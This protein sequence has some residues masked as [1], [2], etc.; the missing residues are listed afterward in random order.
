MTLFRDCLDDCGLF[1]LG[2]SGPKYTWNNRQREE[3]HVK[4]RLDRAVANGDFTT[5][6]DEYNVENIITTAS[7]HLAILIN[8]STS[9][10]DERPPVQQGFRFE[11]AWLRA[12]DYREVLEKA[13]TDRA[14]GDLSLQSTWA[15]L[16]QVA[17]SLQS[18]S[19]ETFGAIRHKI[20]KIERKLHYLRVSASG[21]G[22]DEIRN[23]E[24][25]LCK[26]FEREE[27]MARQ[28]S[29]VEWLREGDRNTSFFHARATARK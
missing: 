14:G 23:L 21:E 5:H 9:R 16:N 10:W 28:R 3:D 6:F 29:R 24:K 7:D 18:W 2:F 12:P 26:L 19:R 11:A 4:V 25:E 27:I 15:T 13:W 22:I 1:D 17:V 8:L 20:R